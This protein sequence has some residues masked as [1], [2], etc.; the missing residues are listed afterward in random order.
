[1]IGESALGIGQGPKYPKANLT[2]GIEKITEQLQSSES[3]GDEERKH[4]KKNSGVIPD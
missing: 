4:L 1:M 3:S 2:S